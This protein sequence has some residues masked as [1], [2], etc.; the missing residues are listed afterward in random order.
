MTIKKKYVQQFHTDNM[1]VTNPKTYHADVFDEGDFILAVNKNRVEGKP[2]H[3]YLV[4][5]KIVCESGE[6]MRTKLIAFSP[7][8][9][10]VAEC[11]NRFDTLYELQGIYDVYSF[12][13]FDNLDAFRKE[14]G[15]E[16]G[17]K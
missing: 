4:V 12:A 1:V 11:L 10:Q 15:Y 8:Y 13:D 17:D 9:S 5:H 16:W 7:K 2:A 3:C 14:H 6:G